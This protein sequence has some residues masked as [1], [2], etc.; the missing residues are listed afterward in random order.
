[1][2]NRAAVS[3]RIRNVPL[4]GL[5]R[6]PDIVEQPGKELQLVDGI[7]RRSAASARDLK[8]VICQRVIPSPFGRPGDAL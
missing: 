2:R 5:L 7:A 4:P 8:Q 3:P 1:M 6:F